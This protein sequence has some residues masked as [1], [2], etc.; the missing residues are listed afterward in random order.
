M[1]Q[2]IS[3]IR[4]PDSSKS[5]RLL[6]GAIDEFCTVVSM[7]NFAKSFIWS[8]GIVVA[9]LFSSVVSAQSAS[10]TYTWIPTTGILTMTWTSSSFICEGPTIGTGTST[11][12]TITSTTMTLPAKND[13]WNR[14]S[15]ITGDIVGTW[16]YSNST[17]GN[18]YTLTF[19]ADGT[20]L[21][22]GIIVQCGAIRSPSTQVVNNSGGPIDH[23]NVG[24]VRFSN[25]LSACGDGCST[26][27]SD[28]SEGT[29][30]VVVFQTA[31]STPVSLGALG[32]FAA[33]NQYAVNIR[34]VSGNY[35][36][37]L[38]KKRGTNSTFNSDTTRVLIASSCTGSAPSVPS[39]PTGLSVTARNGQVSIS[40][41]AVS[42]ATSYRLYMATQ[43][44]VTKSNYSSLPGGMTV[45]GCHQPS[46]PKWLSQRH[47]ILFRCDSSEFCGRECGIC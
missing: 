47:K 5:R 40:W 6:V 11:G 41:N 45:S 22:T 38:W 34:N 15:G 36:G 44:G 32:S 20:L 13:I 4:N 10:G 23:V 42:G 1:D 9:A 27:F 39:A 25:N 29:N 14:P 43:S 12:V 28:V 19:N 18:I 7:L 26:G 17:T 30:T 8:I 24:N 31:T 33:G 21:L 35:C 2:R 37:E 3:L 16:T 46:Y